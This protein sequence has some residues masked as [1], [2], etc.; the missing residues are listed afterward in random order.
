MSN[1]I[2]QT[3]KISLGIELDNE[4]F[5]QEILIHIN[6]VLAILMQL[7][8]GPPGGLYVEGGS[9]VWA[10][11][12]GQGSNDYSLVRSYMAQRVKLLFDPPEIGFVLTSM[13][14]TV[15]EMEWR[16]ALARED[17][18]PP[19]SQLLPNPSVDV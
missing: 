10:D 16:L 18:T 14:E 13:K 19:P 2:L 5:D 6:S 11:L 9:Q 12:L 15:S 8:I 4:D 1:S 3:T 17:R 7:G